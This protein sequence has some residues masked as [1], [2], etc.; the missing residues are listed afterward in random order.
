MAI[1]GGV[2][3]TFGQCAKDRQFFSDV[4][5]EALV[6]DLVVTHNNQA[7]RGLSHQSKYI[8]Q[9]RGIFSLPTLNSFSKSLGKF[10][11]GLLKIIKKESCMEPWKINSDDDDD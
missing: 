1:G 6:L 9:V 5:V 10:L 2:E 11:G 8:I 4:L 7:L 3:A